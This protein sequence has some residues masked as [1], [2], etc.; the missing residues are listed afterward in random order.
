VT[1]FEYR[2]HEVGP[3]V[4]GGAVFYPLEKAKQAL[5]TLARMAPSLPDDLTTLIV[6]LTAPPAPFIPQQLQGTKMC[7][8]A[9]CYTGPQDHGAG[10]VAPLRDLK[11]SVDLLGPVPYVALQSMFDTAAPRGIEAYW[12]TSYL[13]ELTG[14][15][16]DILVAQAYKFRSPFS[17]LHIH[18]LEGEV[19]RGGRDAGA[20]SH[21]DSPYLL[22]ISASG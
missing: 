1:Q 10:L 9:L 8:I 15:L 2:L 19:K 3:Q 16:I 6:F 11:P 21:R 5:G 14:G 22:N 4:F 20:F 13:S 17:Q 18:H 12:K 7:A